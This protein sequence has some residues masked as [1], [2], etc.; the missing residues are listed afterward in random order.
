[1]KTMKLLL[2][3][4]ETYNRHPDLPNSSTIRDFGISR[5]S[6]ALQVIKDVLEGREVDG[7]QNVSSVGD[8]IAALESLDNMVV[9]KVDQYDDGVTRKTWEEFLESIVSGAALVAD[10][11]NTRPQRKQ[12]IVIE[13]NNVRQAL[14]VGTI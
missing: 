8:L 4:C 9:I 14:Q 3:S 10:S 11:G 6:T 2:S 7:G 12:R 5:I 1:M 13:C